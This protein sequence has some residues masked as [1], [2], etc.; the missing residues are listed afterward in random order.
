MAGEERGRMQEREPICASALESGG[1]RCTGTESAASHHSSSFCSQQTS[2][3]IPTD[4][5][6]SF[7]KARKTT[8]H[9]FP[10]HIDLPSIY[11]DEEK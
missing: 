10:Q 9:L 4:L 1:K 3:T 5:T 7:R 11:L 8:F 6:E 2:R